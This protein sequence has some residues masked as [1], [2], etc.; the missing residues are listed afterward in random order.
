M[1]TKIIKQYGE[2]ILCYDLRNARQKKRK[3]YTDF[4]KQLI[5]MHKKE[6]ALYIQKRNLG[7]QPLHPPVQKGWVRYFIVR[8]DVA[9][10]KYGDFFENILKKINTFD[11]YW[12]KDF[13]R[14]KKKRGKKIYVVKEQYLL[15][16][17]EYQFVKLNFTES[18]KQFFEETWELDWNKKIIKKMTFTQPW[19]FVLKIKPNMIDKVRIED[20]ALESNLKAIDNYLEKNCLRGKQSNLLKGR[21]KWKDWRK[22]EK[23]KEVS[24]FRN[25]SLG[26]ILDAIK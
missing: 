17:Y 25:K 10:S 12:R 15:K 16:P 22:V 14:K 13:K 21:Y 20:T 11:Y 23:Y 24:E 6:K 2:D 26:Q 5:Q 8:D 1:D 9:K 19:R 18:E 7:W 4:D 3:Q